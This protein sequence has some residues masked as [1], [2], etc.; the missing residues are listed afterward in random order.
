MNN[1]AYKNVID[2]S[3]ERLVASGKL[4]LVMA[5]EGRPGS[6]EPATTWTRYEVI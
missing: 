3:L 2:V 1:G 4:R 6:D 5:Y